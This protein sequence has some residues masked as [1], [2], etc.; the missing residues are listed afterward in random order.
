[1][2]GV[3]TA[4]IDEISVIGIALCAMPSFECDFFFAGGNKVFALYFLN[5]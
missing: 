4:N 1:M 3:F 5:V 2:E